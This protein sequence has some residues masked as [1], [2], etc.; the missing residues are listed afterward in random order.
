MV[1]VLFFAELQEAA[2]QEKVSL[3]ADGLTVKELKEKILSE[4][5]LNQ[6]DQAMIA[7]NEEYASADA[8]LKTG[9]TVAFIPPVSGG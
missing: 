7:V 3:Q 9:D 4:Y 5:A 8:V 1:N 2:G 6:L